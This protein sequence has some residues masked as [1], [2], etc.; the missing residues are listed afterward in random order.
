MNYFFNSRIQKNLETKLK[1]NDLLSEKIA[2][3]KH[4]L[5]FF[6]KC[7][8]IFKPDVFARNI[9]HLLWKKFELKKFQLLFAKTMLLTEKILRQINAKNIYKPFFEKYVQNATSGV[10]LC[11]IFQANFANLVVRN[12]VGDTDPKKSEVGTIRGDYSMCISEGNLVELTENEEEYQVFYSALF[13][14]SNEQ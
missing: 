5:L 13:N 6:E 9:L 8:I 3:S 1:K 7:I 10:S 4:G 2:R 12:I 11:C 14:E